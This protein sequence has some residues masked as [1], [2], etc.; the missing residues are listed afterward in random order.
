MYQAPVKDLLFVLGEQLRVGQLSATRQFAEFSLELSESVI[1]EAARFATGVLEPLNTVGDRIGAKW[2]P[3]GVRTAPGFVAAYKQYVADGWPLLGISSEHGG[4]GAPLALATAVEEI[5]FATNV[6]FILCPQLGRGAVE[7]LLMAGTPELKA[8]FLPRMISGEW[9]GTMNLTEPQAGSDLAAVRTRAVPDGAV[10]RLFGQKIFI[11]YGEHDMAENIVHLVLARIEGAPPGVK[12]LSLFV[13]PRFMPEGGAR[14]DMRCVSIEHKMGIH[15]SPTCVLAYGDKEG[16]VGYL[17]G[18]ANNGLQYMFIM[19]NSARL[20]VG[21]Q[22]IG[23]SARAWQ[24]AL[25]WARTRVQGKPIGAVRAAGSDAAPTIIQHPDVK[26]LLLL[27]KS[28]VE[29]MRALALYAA[30]QQDM[31]ASL[32]DATAKAQAQARAD[33]L[34]PIVKGWSTEQV[35]HLAS[36]AMQVHGG[37]GYIEETGVAQTLRDARITAIYEGTT[38][39]QANDLIGRKLLRDGGAAISAQI[40]T[41]Q[42]MLKADVAQGAANTA[43]VREITAGAA[44]ALEQL[45]TVSAQLVQRGQ[46]EP[47]DAFAVSVPYLML[48]GFVFGGALLVQGANIAATRL[49]TGNTDVAFMRAKLQ[50]AKFYVAHWLAHAYGLAETVVRGAHSV[51]SAEH[52]LL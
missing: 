43:E 40:E 12:G 24:Q 30:L 34:I 21:V 37:M 11:T 46:T 3:D 4:Q 52:E 28:N 51:S 20:S 35:N 41:L 39:I 10:W 44:A 26:R 36:M 31:G 48:C 50:T 49:A 22:G 8:R 2:T 17:V 38:A 18:E 19:M 23:L 47:V 15:G 42:A 45:R 6:A 1:E 27:M 16:A 14:N 25:N 32:S 13:V 7:S 29:A 33:L 9:T 5:W